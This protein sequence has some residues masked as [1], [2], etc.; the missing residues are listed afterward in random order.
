MLDVFVANNLKMML[1]V[2]HGM[3][4]QSVFY[5]VIKKNR[6]PTLFVVTV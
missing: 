4:F 3:I 5:S 1:P 6:I 2:K